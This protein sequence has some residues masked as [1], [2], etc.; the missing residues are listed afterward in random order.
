MSLRASSAAL[1]G[2]LLLS[3][4]SASA[5]QPVGD[6]SVAPA[7]APVV[8]T[9]PIERAPVPV[10]PASSG[11]ADDALEHSNLGRD[12]ATAQ[13]RLALLQTTAEIQEVQK[14]ISGQVS[15]TTDLPQLVRIAGF[16]GR[17]SA[18]FLMAGALI[19]AQKDDWVSAEWRLTEVL[20]NGV[21]L[22]KRGGREKHVLLFGA[23]ASSAGNRAQLGAPIP[24]PR[25]EPLVQGQGST[26]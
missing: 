17:M 7:P 2:L 19:Q 3:A 21:E 15:G 12:I 4:G 6:P 16:D 5:Q 11:L 25:T 13:R 24:P 26:P 9:A 8:A 23:G 10:T 18:E 1:I 22:T 20:P 14:G